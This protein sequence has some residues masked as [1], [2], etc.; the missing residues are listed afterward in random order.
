MTRLIAKILL[1]CTVVLILTKGNVQAQTFVSQNFN[2]VSN[3]GLPAGWTSTP[4]SQW[5]TGV[6]D[7][8]TPNALNTLH[9]SLN[10]AAH[11]KAVGI[12]GGQAG[13]DGAI[14]SSPGISLPSS[15][16]NTVLKFDIA[17]FG[18]QSNE[19]PPQTEGLI[20]TIS[21]DGGATWSDVSFV[22]PLSNPSNSVWD[23]RSLPMGAY[24]GQN[25]LKF[26][27][28]YNNQGGSLIGAAL[29]N[30]RLINGTDGAVIS[31]FA[32][33]H[34]D[35]S[36]GTGYQ[37]S[38]T[39]A[40]LTG[41]VQNTG[42]A[43]INSYY[44]KYKTDN[45]AVQSSPL[46]ST[47][48]AVMATAHFPAG[49]TVSIPANERYTIKAWIEVTGDVDHT[50]DTASAII[51]GVPSIPVKKPVFEEGTGT[52]CG[53][54]PR[55]AVFMDHFAVTHPNGVAAQIAI[56]NN[57]PMAVSAYD[58]YMSNYAN[59]FPN[60][61]IDRTL[62]KD[63]R[64][65]DSAFTVAQNNFGFADFTLSTPVINGDQVSV[66]VSI[67]PAVTIDNAK[68]ALVITECNVNGSGSNWPQNNYYSGGESGVMGGWENEAPHVSHVNF[69]FV[70]RS[71]TPSP[72]GSSNGLPAQLLTGTTY[73]AT[74]T[75]TLNS[76]KWKINDLQYT[77]LLIN[78][79]NTSIM[80]SAFTTLPTL[81]PALENSTVVKNTES[82]I[83]QAVVYPNPA[84]GKSYLKINIKNTGKAV[85]TISDITGRKLVSIAQQ[86]HPGDN[87]IAMETGKL[88]AGS[89]MVHIAT[90]TANAVRRLQI[91]K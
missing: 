72:D 75:A 11:T 85:V 28:R 55:G 25:N 88:A 91:V 45:G 33:D 86:M 20:F 66:P 68:L 41:T 70:A 34:P 37:L 67:K 76:S 12:D 7:V 56:H 17:Y 38:G 36:T 4:A 69:H 49:L 82:D 81:L 77:A 35:R 5:I 71:I 58:S 24:A 60:I 83:E 15:A 44:I 19:T 16:T 40:T 47:P 80:N 90:E 29:D 53:W 46:I 23:T 84:S 51:I 6:P 59:G 22:N 18:F 73:N 21:T 52:W 30:I 9:Y 3:P 39:A 8:I 89:Y 74:L 10:N 61:V 1:L 27:F 62:L 26:G 57:D 43:N 50:N 87:T 78:G 65:I 31:A 63:P 54:C 79:N 64:D 42:T 13:A 32:G 14:L 2:S 48:L